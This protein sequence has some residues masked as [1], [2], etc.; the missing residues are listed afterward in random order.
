MNELESMVTKFIAEQANSEDAQCSA[1]LMESK[2]QLNQLMQQLKEIVEK[3]KDAEEEAESLSKL[4]KDKTEELAK[5]EAWKDA[6]MAKCMKAREEAI[7]LRDKL[8]L[9]ME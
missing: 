4:L 8:R 9:E 1:Q 6:E 2:H 7:I 5:L 3:L